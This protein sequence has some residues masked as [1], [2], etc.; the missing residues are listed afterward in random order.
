MTHMGQASPRAA[1]IHQHAPSNPDQAIA[2]ALSDLAA[3]SELH[4]LEQRCPTRWR[5]EEPPEDL[6][7]RLS[8][9]VSWTFAVGADG[10]EPP[11]CSL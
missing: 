2:A 1:L 6:L 7:S 10:L 11:T 9:P 3:T 4:R 5:G 8:E